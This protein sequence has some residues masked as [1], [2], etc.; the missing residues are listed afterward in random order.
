MDDIERK[1]AARWQGT[2]K[3]GS[4]VFNME[5][6]LAKDSPY[7]WGTRFGSDKGTNP[8]ELLGAA[9][10]ACYAMNLSGVL[11]KQGRSI[12]SLDVQAGVFMSA[13]APRTITHI[14]LRVTGSVEGMTAE[15]FQAAAEEAKACPISRALAV[16]IEL[17]ASLE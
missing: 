6:G 4:G 16:P 10:A 14:K 1:A 17:E 12:K 8:E 15:E 5:N 3:E 13:E 7:T 9:Q 11:T 2:L